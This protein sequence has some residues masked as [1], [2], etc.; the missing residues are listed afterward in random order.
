MD[1]AGLLKEIEAILDTLLIE[2]RASRGTLRADDPDR[3]WHSDV[4]CAEVL[5]DGAPTMRHDGSVNH[6]AAETIQWITRNKAILKQE[7]LREVR[8]APPRALM[9]IYLAK[10]QMVGPLIIGGNVY[11]WISAH[12]IKSPRRWSAADVIAMEKA[13]AKVA[14]LLLARR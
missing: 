9:D 10:A 7:D 11:G 4:P 2:T 12:E 8:P 1:Q 13:L 6:R 5:R 3:A 14:H